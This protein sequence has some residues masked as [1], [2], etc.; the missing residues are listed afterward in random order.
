MSNEMSSTCKIRRDCKTDQAAGVSSKQRSS[1]VVVQE[2]SRRSPVET[3]T[4][5]KLEHSRQ[6][7]R[8]IEKYEKCEQFKKVK[9]SSEIKFSR[10][11]RQP[12]VGHGRQ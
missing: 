1:A 10:I 11:I 2:R 12:T 5:V 9:D 6:R 7:N 8:N 3:S 4:L